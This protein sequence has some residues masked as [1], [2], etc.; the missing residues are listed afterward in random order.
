MLMNFFIVVVAVLANIVVLA[1]VAVIARPDNG[2]GL[3]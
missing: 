3:A 2:L 1:A